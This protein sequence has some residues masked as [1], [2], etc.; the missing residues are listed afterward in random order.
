MPYIQFQDQQFALGSADLTVGAF[1]G[2]AVRLP[3]DD[4]R[5]SAV[6]RVGADG[7]G[8][9]RRGAADAVVLLNG[10]QLG[11]E[12]SP[13]LHGD[14]VEVGGHAL[15]YGDDKKGGSTQFLSAANL[16]EGLRSKAGAPRKPTTATGG[17]LVSLVDGREYGVRDAG[18]TFGREIGCDIVIASTEVSRKHAQIAPGE[19]GYLVTDL[20][21]NGVFVNGTRIDKRQLL[22]RGDVLKIGPEE[23]RFYADVAKPAPDAAQ[24]HA[25]SATAASAPPSVPAPTA[26]PAPVAAT[27]ATPPTPPC[28]PAHR[29]THS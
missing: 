2:A 18:V 15:R 29:E 26:A 25:A 6:L 13:I 23:F 16:P 11:Q 28:F 7:T 10:L 20:S 24:A 27:P 14:K 1:D 19:G 3:G 9:I 4:P 21:T 5:A 22:G 17:R 8:I 12:P